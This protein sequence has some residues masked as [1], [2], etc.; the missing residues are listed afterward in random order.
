MEFVHRL[1]SQDISTRKVKQGLGRSYSFTETMGAR[2]MSFIREKAR[3]ALVNRGAE[4][5]SDSTPRQATR[6]FTT[7]SAEKSR[8]VVKKTR[9][10]VLT[11]DV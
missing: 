9:V 2:K 8:P 4:L 10:A 1:N 6:R 3:A 7:K 11:A 5:S